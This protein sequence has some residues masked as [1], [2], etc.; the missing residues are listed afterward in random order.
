MDN[1]YKL[2][3]SSSLNLTFD[4]ILKILIELLP[5]LLPILVYCLWLFVRAIARKMIIKNLE[6]KAGGIID[7]TYEEIKKEP[8]VD[9]IISN[10]SL[11]NRQ[12][13]IVLYLSFFIAI[14]CFLF[15]AIR[16]PHIE[17]GE[18]VPAYIE[19]GEVVPSKI[20]APK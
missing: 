5:A 11:Q 7:A 17:K 20:V 15:F 1:E 14:I 19:N 3:N 12:F 2:I 4:M 13:I 10:F 16:V 18:Y 9:P 8:K 6:K